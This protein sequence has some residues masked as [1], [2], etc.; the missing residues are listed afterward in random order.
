MTTANEKQIGGDHYKI[1]A[2]QPW[3]YIIANNLG[4]LEGTAIKYITRWKSKGGIADIDKA[5]HFLEK[6]KETYYAQ[7]EAVKVAYKE[8]FDTIHRI[9]KIRVTEDGSQ[10]FS[11]EPVF[12]N[13]EKAVLKD[14]KR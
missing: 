11:M 14:C 12:D 9:G 5:I 6:L 7:E 4:Y 13:V 10:F 3:D 1:N 2:I 8:E